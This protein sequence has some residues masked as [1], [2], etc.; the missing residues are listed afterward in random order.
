MTN[1]KK[2][3][4]FPAWIVA[5]FIVSACQKPYSKPIVIW[6][7]RSD[8]VPYTELFNSSQKKAK[9]I[10]VYKEN[11]VENFPPE[12]DSEIPDI[13]IGSWL[14]NESIRGNFTP[15]DYLFEDH[16]LNPAHFYPQLL[17]PGNVNNKQYLLP[18]SFN[19]SVLIFST[20]YTNLIPDNYMLSMDEIQTAAQAFNKMNAKK[21]YTAMGFAPSWNP[22]FLYQAVKLRN[23]DFAEDKKSKYPFVWNADNML[24]ALTY[25]REWTTT[26]NTST[27]AENDYKFKYL[28]N[29]PIKWINDK[30]CLFVHSTSNALFTITTEKLKNID[31][32]WLQ[33]GNKLFVEDDMISLGLYKYSDNLAAAELFVLWFMN[34]ENQKE[35]LSWRRQLNLYTKSFGIA[36]GFSSLRTVNERIFPVFY[37]TL[38]GNLPTAEYLTTPN[39]LPA[40]WEDIK[41][42]VVIPFLVEAVNTGN[43][44]INLDLPRFIDEWERKAY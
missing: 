24:S 37:P 20:D 17:A 4:F 34:E 43:Q 21:V 8:F 2:R 25:L 33:E 31:F 32:R 35:M 11:P 44:T 13:I 1:K 26:I 36:G 40:Q 12:Q 42:Q 38:L 6:T 27:Q 18:V 9:A 16:L 5:F 14:K 39:I 22:D 15:L 41:K 7:N 3:V 29:P 28:Y 30:E 19:L 23:A 10:V